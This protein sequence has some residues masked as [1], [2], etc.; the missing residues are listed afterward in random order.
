[1]TSVGTSAGRLSWRRGPVNRW[2]QLVSAI[3]VMA[4]IAAVLCV[5]RLLRISPGAD[6][7]RSLAA[8][9]NAFAAFILAETLLVPVEAWLGERVNPRLLTGAGGLLV[10]LGA[11]GGARVES[12][13]A[14]AGWY[15]LGGAGA[16]M[17]YGGTVARA[18]KRFTDRKASC[19]GVT[20]AACAAV[21]GLAL[22]AYVTAV[23]SPGAIRLL[24]VIG[25]GQAVVILVATL[26]ILAPPPSTPPP[27][28]C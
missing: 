3:G 1:M 22:A 20:A 6:L 26:L 12:V 7:G 13:G 16:G 9:E 10:L 4:G 27:P 8:A 5:W 19:V 15:A 23:G 28:G 2:V 25:A 24:A 18:L 21:A 14:L 17:V 11:I